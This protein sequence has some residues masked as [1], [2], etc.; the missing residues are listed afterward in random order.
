MHNTVGET[1]M[2]SEGRKV[3]EKRVSYAEIYRGK[4]EERTLTCSEKSS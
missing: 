2:K 4:E 3:N 1:N